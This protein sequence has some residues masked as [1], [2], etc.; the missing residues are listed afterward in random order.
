[1]PGVGILGAGFFGAFHA[2]AIAA[3]PELRLVAACAEQSALAEAFVAE[4][5]G[6][7][8]CD[9]RAMLDDR[10]VDIVAITAPHHLHAE[11]A[12]ASGR[13]AR[14]SGKADGAVGGRMQPHHRRSGS[15]PA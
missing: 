9:W 10:A 8:F 12:V 11:L 14:L 5:G 4:H 6:T 2:R 3:L 13:Q 7:P 1:M 15:W